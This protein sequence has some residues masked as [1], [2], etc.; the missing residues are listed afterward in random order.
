MQRRNVF[1][2][3]HKSGVLIE[4]LMALNVGSGNLC[5]MVKQLSESRFFITRYYY[6]EIK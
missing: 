2:C 6:F 3:V 5:K 1:M 4:R